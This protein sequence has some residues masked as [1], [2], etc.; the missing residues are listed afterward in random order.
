MAEGRSSSSP[1][2]PPSPLPMSSP[3]DMGPPSELSL[4]VSALDTMSPP[5]LSS[6]D[7]NS[8][9]DIVSRAE[10]EDDEPPFKRKKG[11]NRG[12]IVWVQV[13]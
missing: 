6:G 3:D 2:S 11:G 4:L 8:E 7:D 12:D 9:G 5:E 1:H 13:G 10:Q